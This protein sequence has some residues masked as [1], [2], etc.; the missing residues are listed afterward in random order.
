MRYLLL[1]LL[2]STITGCYAQS[3]DCSK[4]KTG[5]FKYPND[6]SSF[7]ITR[8]DSIQ[9]EFDKKNNFKMVG[10]VEWLSDC[11]YKLT[12]TEVSDPR[13]SSLVGVSFT[14]DITSASDNTYKYHAYDNEK[15]IKGK[16]IK[17]KN[18]YKH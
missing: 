5:T 4:F 10:S 14:V 7:V 2:L 17:I 18:S 3:K 11:Q 15:E 1:T 9:V 6:N 12:Y 8:N 13:A 16:M